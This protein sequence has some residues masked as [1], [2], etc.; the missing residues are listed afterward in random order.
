[1]KTRTL[2]QTL[3]D[4]S[5]VA[6]VE[7]NGPGYCQDRKAWLCPGYYLWEASKDVARW[8]G[9][10]VYTI[11][12][13]GYIICRT[14]YDYAKDNFFD[15]VGDTEH[16]SD[17][18]DAVDVLSQEYEGQSMTVA[19]VLGFM[20]EDDEFENKFDA[21]RAY[22]IKS[23]RPDKIIYFADNNIAYMEKDPPIQLCIWKNLQNVLTSPFTVEEVKPYQFRYRW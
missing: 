15:L 7:K 10:K 11:Q 5:N 3:E 23:R 20:R 14:A 9:Q 6:H 21:V 4:R 12:K 22:P 17:F 8:W 19:M 18:W 2:Y 13:K 1:M 16:N